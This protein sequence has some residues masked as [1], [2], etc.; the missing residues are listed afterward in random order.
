MATVSHHGAH[1]EEATHHTSWWILASSWVAQ[2][3]VIL[4]VTVVNIA[5]P[6]ISRALNFSATDLQWVVT[7]TSSSRAD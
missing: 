4:D 1:A 2:F 5:L 6:S 3:M 7:V